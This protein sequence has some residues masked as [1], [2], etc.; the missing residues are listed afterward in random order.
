M[1]DNTKQLKISAAHY[2]VDNFIQSGMLVG[3]GVGSTAVHAT[4]RIAEHLQSGKLSSI[5]GIPASQSIE[6][7]A[8]SLGIPLLEFEPDTRID[9]TIDGADEVDPDLNLIKGGGGA[10]T[11]EKIVAQAS[12]REV[13]VIDDSKQSSM[14]GTHWPIPIEVIPFG[15]QTQMGYL[16]SLDGEPTLRLDESG[17]P[18]VTDQG[19]YI[20]DA[21]FGPIEQP[22]ILADQIKKRAGIVEHGLFIHLATDIVVASPQG[23]QHIKHES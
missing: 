17:A 23:I 8:R 20:I 2:A 22:I 21:D 7:E 5:T 1:N 6:M 3:L 13:I 11:R 14:L 19:N 4:R 18:Y 16:Q 15:W 12:R 10:L 9:I